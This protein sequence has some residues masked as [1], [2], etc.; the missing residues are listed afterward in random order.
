MP[1][2]IKELSLRNF[3]AFGDERQNAPMSKIT[4]IYGPNSAGKSSIIQALLLLK[5]SDEDRR[6]IGGLVPRGEYVDLG[7]FRTMMHKHQTE[8]AME[9]SIKM[10]GQVF[11]EG[12][13]ENDTEVNI[14]AIFNSDKMYIDIPTLDSVQ[15]TLRNAEWEQMELQ[16]NRVYHEKTDAKAIIERTNNNIPFEWDEN[17]HQINDFIRKVCSVIVNQESERDTE[18][19]D[20]MRNLQREI[21]NR[22]PN[23]ITDTSTVS[24]ADFL[25]QSMAGNQWC[26]MP[27]FDI[28]STHIHRYTK[29]DFNG[30][31]EPDGLVHP[32]DFF[33][34]VSQCLDTFSRYFKLCME[35]LAYLGPVL[36]DP[37]RYYYGAGGSLS[38]VGKR[39]EHT[40]DIISDNNEARTIVNEWFEKFQIPYTL[41]GAESVASA[42]ELTGAIDAM[43]LIDKRTCTRV[44]PADVGFGISQI[45]PVIVEGIAGSSH[46]V[47]VDQPEVH[48]HPGLQAEIADLMIETRNEKQW[49]V[50]T[51]SELLARRIQTRIAEGVI[52][53]SEVSILYVTPGPEG[54]TISV[55]GIDEEGDW[56]TEWPAGFFEE[57][58]HEMFNQLRFNE[59][60][61]L[62]GS[63]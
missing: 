54:S 25:R 23:P 24:I 14:Q 17:I 21:F 62:E 43:L 60:R 57:R 7:G 39:G 28:I 50:E 11:A 2:Q 36:D 9:I 16:F 19:V 18:F 42:N 44:T 51:H 32:F 63:A 53:P 26:F 52:N 6:L 47:C 34:Y 15:Y 46:T 30:Y 13:E 1:V 33:S 10:H 27:N 59:K 29:D 20:M 56:L 5:Q 8:N 45:L 12:E 58:Q 35:S 37:R 38:T 48:L 40:F 55:L 4:L 49:I 22:N 3:K 61:R 41:E 31:T